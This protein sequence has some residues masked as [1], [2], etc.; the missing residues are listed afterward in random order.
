MK[1]ITLVCALISSCASAQ[2]NYLDQST[3]DNFNDDAFLSVPRHPVYFDSGDVA[4][5]CEDYLSL[6]KA[7]HLKETSDN[8]LAKTEYLSCE[9]HGLIQKSNKLVSNKLALPDLTPL[10]TKLDLR[11]IPSSFGPQLNESNYTL[12]T[13]TQ[14]AVQ[15]KNNQLFINTPQQYF[16]FRLKAVLDLNSNTVPDWVIWMVDESKQG[17][18]KAYA[19]LI[20]MDAQPDAPTWQ[21]QKFRQV[22]QGQ[23]SD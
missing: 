3:L 23:S 2:Y 17:T 11:S 7:H 20:V 5:N 8:Y 1:K 14:Q 12:S 13:L 22:Y 18:Y 19:T 6:I 9:V 16:E 21:A 15:Y 10:A 4:H